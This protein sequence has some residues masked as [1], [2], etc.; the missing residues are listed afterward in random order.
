MNKST[1]FS[2][3]YATA[4]LRF[5]QAANCLGWTLE[6]HSIGCRGP[7]GEDLTIDVAWSENGNP[8]RTL[9]ISSGVHGVEG[10]FGSAV[11]L[12]M[13]EQWATH[14]TPSVRCVFLHGLN[15]YG[16]SWLRRFDENNVD[17]NR[18]FLLEGEQYQGAPVGYAELNGLLNPRRPP[19]RWNPF[20]IKALLAIARHGMPALRQSIAAGQ[21][22]F[23]Q[24][25]FFGGAGPTQMQQLL[26]RLLAR[27]LRGSR[28]VVHLDFHTGLGRSSGCKLLIDY[29]LTTSA[30]AHLTDWFGTDSFEACDSDGMSYD[31]RGGLG[32]WCVSR[33]LASEY[34]FACAEFGTFGPIKVLAG[35]RAENHAHHW[36]TPGSASTVHL[37]QELKELFC[38]SDE[39]W[40]LNVLS[41]SLRLVSQAVDGLN[42]S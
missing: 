11:Q 29:P 18:N 17:P 40:R 1:S 3:D 26:H 5:R 25:L 32:R 15:P 8:E 12:A 37:K 24:G 35:L 23:P 19:S 7:N 14:G 42:Q 41:Q 36:G 2:P 9:V 13:L 30:R 6:P 38:P 22:E 33:R 31:A 21:H 39:R 27:W 10:F 28:S 20:F 16:F 34:L 4:R